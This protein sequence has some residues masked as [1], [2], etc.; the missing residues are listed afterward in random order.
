MIRTRPR[1]PAS[2]QSPGTYKLRQMSR[3][4]LHGQ[5]GGRTNAAIDILDQH[6][7]HPVENRRAEDPRDSLRDDVVVWDTGSAT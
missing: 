6:L 1:I 7:P 3:E 5:P 4:S 2:L